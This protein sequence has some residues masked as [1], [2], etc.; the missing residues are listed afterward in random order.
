MQTKYSEK[1]MSNAKPALW[2]ESLNVLVVDDDDFQIDFTSDVLADL[3]I[4]N[5]STASSG[6]DALAQLKRA[7]KKTNLVLC[8][9]HMPQMDGFELMR[10]LTELGYAGGVIVV[11]GQED[12]VLHTANL[13]AQLGSFQFLG[14]MKK[15]LNKDVMQTAIEKLH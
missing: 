4:K 6:Q 14:E 3:G 5:I 12:K 9:L 11:S 1:N 8:D 15:P 10:Q 7:I 13:V 2:W